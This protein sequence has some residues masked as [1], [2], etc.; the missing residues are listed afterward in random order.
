MVLVTGGTGFLGINL[1]RLLVSQA[2]RVRVLTRSDQ[3]P[4]GLES[5]LI[6]FRRGDVT[7]PASLLDAVRSCE[8]VYHLAGW[9]QITPW[10]HDQ[11]RRINVEGTRL[12][13]RA[14]LEAGVRR[15]VHTSSI[16]AIGCGA[17][18]HPADE[19]T[20]WNTDALCIPYYLSKRDSEQVVLEFVDRGLDAVIVNPAYV[21]GPWDVKPTAGRMILRVATGR[22]HIYPRR[23][24]INFVDVRQVAEGHVKAMS[25]GSTGQRYILGGENISYRAFFERVAAIAGVRPPRWGVDAWMLAGPAAVG[26]ALGRLFPAVF[27][28]LNPA[29]LRSGFI[30]HFVTAEKSRRELALEPL[31]I[32]AAIRDT[33]AWFAEHGYYPRRRNKSDW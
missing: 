1:V 24:G 28:D 18:D 7:D 13:C 33:L 10:G 5:E 17:P 6:E 3:R 4:P 8:E 32:D 12:V 9:V 31:P 20:P 16:A 22:Q 23:G 21:I 11:A 2:Q 14:A 26:G 19:T 29:I 25:L 15:L 27:R 30:E